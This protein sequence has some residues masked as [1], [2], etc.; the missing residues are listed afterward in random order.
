MG[1]VCEVRQNALFP[2][3]F[4]NI[5]LGGVVA[6]ETLGIEKQPFYSPAVEAAPVM[7]GVPLGA[8]GR[9][10]LWSSREGYVKG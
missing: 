6:S 10:A 3:R 1:G 2:S 4:V 9:Q 5:Q 7:C 8:V